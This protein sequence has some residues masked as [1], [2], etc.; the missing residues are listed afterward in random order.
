[1]LI[2][3]KGP[4]TLI[5]RQDSNPPNPRTL[6]RLT[7]MVCFDD[8]FVMNDLF[9]YMEDVEQDHFLRDMYLDVAGHDERGLRMYER[10]V[11]LI[12]MRSRHFV[13]EWVVDRAIL[14]KIQT[15]Y[16][17]QPLSITQTGLLVVHKTVEFPMSKQHIGWIYTTKAEAVS[18]F[19]QAVCSASCR[20]AMV[21]YM[22]EEAEKLNHYLRGQCYGYELLKDGIF[23]EER[24]GLFGHLPPVMR[25]IEELLPDACKGMT[26][27]LESG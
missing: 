22:V 18:H 10:M 2:S 9:C 5:L 12:W 7:R 8:R 27:L 23:V 17:I 19:G 13:D 4:Y 3:R 16:I 26:R 25:K 21:N 1:M 11:E 6:D 24:W 14:R 15:K 20:R